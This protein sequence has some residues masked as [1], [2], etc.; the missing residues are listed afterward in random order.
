MDAGHIQAWTQAGLEIGAHTRHHVN[1]VDGEDAA[2]QDEIQHSRLDLEDVLGQK[3][4]QFCYP[5]GIH[6]QRHV[7]MVAQAGYIAATTTERGQ[8]LNG[9]DLLTLR[10][11]PI[12]RSTYWPQF[13][14]KVLTSYENKHIP[15]GTAD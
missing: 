2:M 4:D 8:V 15:H 14:L 11:I 10:R 12:V 6:D 13:L 9:A 3:V 5:F 7:E 1:L